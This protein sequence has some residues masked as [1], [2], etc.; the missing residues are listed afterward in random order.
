MRVEEEGEE[1]GGGRGRSE[2]YMAVEVEGGK[3]RGRGGGG[4]GAD[5]VRMLKTDRLNFEFVV[6]VVRRLRVSQLQQATTALFPK[7][8][9][10]SQNM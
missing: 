6:V 10:F 7:C 5:E 4:G 3:G 9:D 8:M 2:A 1:G